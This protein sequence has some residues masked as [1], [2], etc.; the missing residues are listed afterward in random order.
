MTIQ[1]CLQP[2]APARLLLQG[3]PRVG[4]F[5]GG[6]RCPEDVPFPAC[7]RACLDYFGESLGYRLISAHNTTWRLDNTFTFLMGVS[8]CA[9]RLSWRPGWHGDHSEIQC[10]SDDPS[11]PF[12]RAFEAIGYELILVD[13][14]GRHDD[15]QLYRDAILNSLREKDRP[16]I[17]F[18]VIG[19]PEACLVTGYD[20]HGDT[21]IGWNFFQDFPEYNDG[22]EFEASGEFRKLGWFANTQ[23]L[24]IFG[25]KQPITQQG[26]LYRKA[27]RWALEVM[28]TPVTGGDLPNGGCYNGIAA[29]QAWADALL[30]DESFPAEMSVLRERF[31]MHD[32]AVGMVAE[33]R[34]YAAKFMEQLALAEPELEQE[35]LAAADCFEMEHDL[36]WQIW[37]LVGG[38]GRSEEHIR[39]LADPPT[40]RRI[41]PLILQAR[42][43]DREAAKC[44]E[45]ALQK[46]RQ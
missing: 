24:M 11:A 37:E 4:F 15:E 7:L 5:Q 31:F 35:C 10:M 18:G 27:L 33:G 19:P 43:I 14:V 1:R 22:V 44:I 41:V 23:S 45:Q 42:E 25:E 9:F 12:R 16:V 36:M 29:Y 21:L 32:D 40:R 17:A 8:G 34:W 26:A 2:A 6:E 3:V 28:R 13:P 46:K 39:M 38:N 30:C 20:E